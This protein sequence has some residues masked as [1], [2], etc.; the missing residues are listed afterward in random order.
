[1]HLSCILCKDKRF[2]SDRKNDIFAAENNL[3]IKIV[4]SYI[5]NKRNKQLTEKGNN[6]KREQIL[7]LHLNVMQNAVNKLLMRP[8]FIYMLC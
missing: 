8:V 6:L 1:M 7:C 4:K 3:S 5:K 2:F